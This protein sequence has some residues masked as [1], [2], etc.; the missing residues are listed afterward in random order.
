MLIIRFLHSNNP[1][2][3]CYTVSK[4]ASIIIQNTM[5]VYQLQLTLNN[6]GNISMILMRGNDSTLRRCDELVSG[7]RCYWLMIGTAARSHRAASLCISWWCCQLSL[8]RGVCPIYNY[9]VLTKFIWLIRKSMVKNI[10]QGKRYRNNLI[11]WF[12]KLRSLMTWC[13]N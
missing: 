13:C 9:T 12:D 11:P 5:I 8:D 7:L 1:P 4:A 3:G 2:K 10:C 6:Y